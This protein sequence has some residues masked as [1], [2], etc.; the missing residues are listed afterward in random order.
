MRIIVYEEVTQT[1]TTSSRHT[2]DYMNSLHPNIQAVRHPDHIATTTLFWSHHEKGKQSSLQYRHVHAHVKKSDTILTPV[3]LCDNHALAVGGLDLCYGRWD[4]HSHPLADV[5]PSDMQRTLFPGQDYNNARIEDFQN[6]TDWLSNNQSRLT[7]GR[8]PWHDVHVTMVGPVALDMARHVAERWNFVVSTTPEYMTDDKYKK[9]ALPNGAL[10]IDDVDPQFPEVRNHPHTIEWEQVGEKFLHP[11]TPQRFDYSTPHA[12]WPSN[13]TCNIQMVR[14]SADWSSGILK[15]S[16]IQTAYLQL[17]EE[18]EHFIYIENQFF[19]TATSTEDKQIE[20]QLGQALVHRILRAAREGTAFHV[21]I[22]I[23]CIPCFAGDL[24]KA[25]GLLAIMAYQYQSICRGPTS[26]FGLLRQ[27]GV[28]PAQYFS[29]YNL[30][31]FDRILNDG[32]GIEHA[33]RVSGVSYVEME[34][35]FSRQCIGD[36]PEDSASWYKEHPEVK[37]RSVQEVDELNGRRQGQRIAPESSLLDK[38]KLFSEGDEDIKAQRSAD[39]RE[40][41][42]AEENSPPELKPILLPST[43]AQADQVLKRFSALVPEL[44]LRPSIASNILEGQPRTEDEKWPGASDEKENYYT[45]ETYIH[46]K[47]MIVDDRRV[48]IGSANINDRS[49]CGDR[50]SEVAVVIED[51]DMFASTMNGEPWE[52]SKFASSFRRFLWRQHLG[53]IKP[54]ECNADIAREYPTDAMRPAP[55]PIPDPASPEGDLQEQEWEQRVADP[56]SAELLATW[57]AQAEENTAIYAE[58]FHPVPDDRVRDWKDVCARSCMTT[59][60]GVLGTDSP[61]STTPSIRSRRRSEATWPTRTCRLSTSKSAC[62]ASEAAS[63]P[64]P[65]SFSTNSTCSRRPRAPK[66]TN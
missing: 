12:P 63:S 17:I 46:S 31:G 19:I 50:D 60:V 16:S 10:S 54:Q 39:R 57:K 48:I 33:E 18:A 55:H 56:L 59:L 24:D 3:V 2:V 4:T 37:I 41:A 8:M 9:L 53:W 29:F 25:D 34:A 44:N 47:L 51:H 26:I 6:V 5:H 64:S 21:V 52:A 14:S 11:F 28:N 30:R 42:Q 23:P 66:S 62:R 13:G 61:R 27:A 45:E 36:L 65:L 49:M 22:C 58:V 7:V 40:A 15:E 32:P 1:A 20:N 35:S 38:F 43:A